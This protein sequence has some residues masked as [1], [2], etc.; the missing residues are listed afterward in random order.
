M[1]FYRPYFKMKRKLN[2]S[3][4]LLKHILDRHCVYGGVVI[5]GNTIYRLGNYTESMYFRSASI[6]KMITAI[7][8]MKWV[9]KNGLDLDEPISN[10]SN[11]LTKNITLRM[12]LS[13]TSGIVD[14][15]AYQQ[16]LKKKTSLSAIL[17]D[18]SSY[19]NTSNVF[20]YSN[21]GFGIIGSL[22]EDVTKQSLE[23]WMQTN[24]FIP[25]NLSCTYDIT[26]LDSAVSSYRTIPLSTKPVFDSFSRKQLSQ[27]INMSDPEYHY[28]LSAGNAFITPKSL[29]VLLMMFTR[30]GN[31][32]IKPKSVSEMIKPHSRYG[33][34][35][36]T[37]SY[38]LGMLIIQDRGTIL[39]G[40]QGV[41][42]GSI[43]GAFFSTD[44]KHTLVSLNA[45]A[46]RLREGKLLI[47]NRDLIH[48]AY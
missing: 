14:G 43:N 6:T 27:P 29:Q 38:G 22:I 23:E 47:L 18:K 20:T 4:P 48:W 31:G 11:I 44:T 35:S 26:T 33:H 19:Q 8:V 30:Q 46:S 24:V 7:G 40:H 15:L 13:H 42:Y 2:I 12:L 9:E 45:G 17:A 37:L 5:N 34:I 36:P 39:Y 21:L 41:A 16:S 10:F 32:F 28:Q 3:N 1:S 25:L